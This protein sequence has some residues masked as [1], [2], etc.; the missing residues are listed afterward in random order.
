MRKIQCVFK[1]HSCRQLV[2]VYLSICELEVDL[3]KNQCSQL[4][5][6]IVY[7]MDKDSVYSIPWFST[8][9]MLMKV[10]FTEVVYR[11]RN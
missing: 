9:G 5:R 10:S 11:I 1:L 8:D 7:S 4:K 3:N 6:S 2:I